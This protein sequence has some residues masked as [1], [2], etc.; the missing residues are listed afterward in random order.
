MVA[1]VSELHRPIL[2][3]GSDAEEDE[4]DLL[5]SDDYEGEFANE[6]STAD[7]H[8][9][10]FGSDAELE[11]LNNANSDGE[12]IIEE[13][14]TH[15]LEYDPTVLDDIYNDWFATQAEAHHG[16]L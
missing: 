5:F 10:I 7:L 15:Y 3:S 14:G 13:I 6:S 4:E 16:S 1:D 2:W 8:Q 9:R 12:L 11:E